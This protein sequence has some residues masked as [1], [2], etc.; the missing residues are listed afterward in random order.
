M[1]ALLTLPRGVPRDPD[2]SPAPPRPRDE[3]I[4]IVIRPGPG[5]APA[6]G[7]KPRPSLAMA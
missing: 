6:G 3:P 7:R 4:G 5:A 2:A 1:L